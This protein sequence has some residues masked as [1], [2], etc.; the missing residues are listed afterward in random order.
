[1]LRAGEIV[2]KKTLIYL[3]KGQFTKETESLLKAAQ[4]NSK[5]TIILKTKLIIRSKIASVD[6][7][8]ME[9]K[10]LIT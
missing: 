1:M 3:R 7:E 5:G 4:N 10:P 6:Y 8:M 9:M 2:E